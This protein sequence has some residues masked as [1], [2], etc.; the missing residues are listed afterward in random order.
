MFWG[1]Y[2]AAGRLRGRV[3]LQAGDALA[4]IELALRYRAPL[5]SRLLGHVRSA[6]LRA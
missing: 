2:E 3:K 5:V 4:A 6:S 1:R